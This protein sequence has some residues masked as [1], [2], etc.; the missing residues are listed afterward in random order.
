MKHLSEEKHENTRTHM[1]NSSS[2]HIEKS[3]RRYQLDTGG[4]E[5]TQ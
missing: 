2:S 4:G 5:E 3:E 1:D